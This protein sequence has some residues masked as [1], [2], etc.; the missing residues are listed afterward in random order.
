MCKLL[1]QI[2]ANL[3]NQLVM[4]NMLLVEQL[5]KNMSE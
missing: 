5:N 2:M 1:C 3:T 4:K